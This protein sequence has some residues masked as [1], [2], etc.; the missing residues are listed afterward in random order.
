MRYADRPQVAVTS[1][2]SGGEQLVPIPYGNGYLML[3]LREFQTALSRGLV[4]RPSE[5]PATDGTQDDQLVDAAHMGRLL[6][7]AD[8]WVEQAAKTGRIP[9]V[10]V[11]RYLRFLPRAVLAALQE[12]G[13]A[14]L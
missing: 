11:G 4:G 7:V 6:G 14:D 5:A 10:R 1:C 3:T 9:A 13:H 2:S 12:R 8:T